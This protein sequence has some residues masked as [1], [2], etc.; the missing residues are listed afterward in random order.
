DLALT[1]EETCQ[2]LDAADTSLSGE[3]VQSIH[4]ATGGWIVAVRLALMS[5]S[6]GSSV[7]AP[8]V[9]DSPRLAHDLCAEIFSTLSDDARAFLSQIVVLDPITANA[10]AAVTEFPHSVN[11]LAA[12]VDQGIVVPTGQHAGDFHLSEIWQTFLRA[13]H[14]ADREVHRRAA[15]WY[16]AAHDPDRAISHAMRTDPEMAAD[17][18]RRYG[19]EAL[20]RGEA[21]R[22]RTWIVGMSE[23]VVCADAALSL[24]AAWALVQC[25]EVDRAERY[26]AHPQQPPG[27]IAALRARIAA[28]RGERET[29]IQWS[30]RAISQVDET[31]AA[32]RAEMVLNLGCAYLDTGQVERAQHRF[33]AVLRASRATQQDRVAVFATYLTGK[34]Q[35]ALGRL[36]LA[37][38]HYRRGIQAYGDLAIAGVLHA[39]LAELCYER[40]DVEKAHEHGE[41]AL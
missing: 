37:S 15:R 3:T 26:L 6:V 24:L 8:V 40:N 19:W 2:V 22:V 23:Q 32:L 38:R 29:M 35:M 21:H 17:L 16:Q 9:A 10:C 18:T 28:F 13:T 30:E 39:G 25:G 4:Q 7:P 33:S 34:A 12:L 36:Q 20:A 31:P 14:P 5:S 1:L 41:R 11:L 27:A